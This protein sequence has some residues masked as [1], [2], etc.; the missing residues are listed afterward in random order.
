MTTFHQLSVCLWSID[1]CQ[2]YFYT[3]YSFWL[4]WG[5]WF[6]PS[7]LI[8]GFIFFYSSVLNLVQTKWSNVSLS[9][10][11]YEYVDKICWENLPKSCKQTAGGRTL[12]NLSVGV[13]GGD[14]ND[15]ILEKSGGTHSMVT[16][17]CPG[18]LWSLLFSGLQMIFKKKK[19]TDKEEN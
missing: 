1:L 5:G 16:F 9:W 18:M 8:W 11:I 7:T 15:H 6:V 17:S 12:L 3:L 13:S 2:Y 4:R 10:I 19:P 14:R